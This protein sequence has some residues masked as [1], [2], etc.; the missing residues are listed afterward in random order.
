MSIYRVNSNLPRLNQ[1]EAIND[2][3]IEVN[4]KVEEGKFDKNEIDIIYGLL[5]FDRK[6][7][8]NQTIGGTVSNYT[9]WSNLRTEVGYNIWKF[10]PT[11]YTYNA[12]NNLY[13]DN[14][15][16]DNR[17]EANSESATS[18]DKVYLYNG[19]SGSG[20]T[21]NTT[22]AG[23]EGGTVFSLMDST[24]DYFYV[25]NSATFT[26]I[27]IEFATRGSNYTLKVEYYDESSGTE[28]W[29]EL[30]ANTNDLSDGTSK[31]ESDGKITWTVP[32]D[33]GTNTVNSQT[34]YWIR[35]STT[36]S[37][38]TTATAYVVIP[39]DSV[40]GL[41]A[42]SSTELLEEDWA[43]CSYTTAIY[44]T[45][46]NTGDS[47]Y[48][49]DFFITSSSSSTNLEN[50]FVHNHTYTA[51]YEDSG[52]D[53]VVTKTA[54]YTITGNEGIILIDASSGSVGLTLPTAVGREGKIFIIKLLTKGSNTATISTTGSQK[55]D[56]SSTYTY[57]SNYE[58]VTVVSDGSNWSII[59]LK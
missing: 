18:F 47:T 44:V 2:M 20:F 9:S 55:I 8:R 25:G 40:I 39:G 57:S 23:T 48:E 29:A 22:E 51:D 49:G 36:S 50:Y 41:L 42:M 17:G 1:I 13:L 53:Q 24:T 7:L 32:D 14:Q 37:P 21:D 12:L 16:L 56:G 26:G 35:I 19:D 10:T 45:V 31:L 11:T 30:T 58:C 54:N 28:T 52:Y 6:F 33:W 38:T 59:G 3:V 43:W 5:G 27:K 46:R 4:G 15:K 34:K